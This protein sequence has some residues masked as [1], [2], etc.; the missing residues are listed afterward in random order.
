MDNNFTAE[1][2]C[3]DDGN[4]RLLDFRSVKHERWHFYFFKNVKFRTGAQWAEF[5]VD[6]WTNCCLFGL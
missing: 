5:K 4:L 3:I 6:D 2:L 1:S